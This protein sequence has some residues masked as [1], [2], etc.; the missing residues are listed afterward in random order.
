MASCT[1]FQLV[2][3]R[4]LTSHYQTIAPG[5]AMSLG[6]RFRLVVSYKFFLLHSS[7]TT[8]STKGLQP[9]SVATYNICE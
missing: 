1:R 8:I 4:P 3:P 6:V 5:V 2:A 9:H 7:S